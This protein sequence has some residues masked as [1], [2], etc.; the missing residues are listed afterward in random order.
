MEQEGF[1]WF[2]QG[3]VDELM[4]CDM[5]VLAFVCIYYTRRPINSTIEKNVLL[6]EVLKAVNYT[7]SYKC[8]QKPDFRNDNPKLINSNPQEL[9]NPPRVAFSQRQLA[10]GVVP[11]DAR[12]DIYPQ[13]YLYIIHPLNPQNQIGSP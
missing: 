2:L 3:L 4:S 5:Y 13:G 7:P 1:R 11:S 8:L 12:H 10:P 6:I 9:P